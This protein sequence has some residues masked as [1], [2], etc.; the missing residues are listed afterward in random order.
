MKIKNSEL[1]NLCVSIARILKEEA[2][3]ST[4]MRWGLIRNKELLAGAFKS[5]NEIRTELVE[6]YAVK[7]KDGKPELKDDGLSWNLGD[8]EE[9][10]TED[11]LPTLNEEVEVA[12][13]MID[14]NDFPAQYNEEL[15]ANYDCLF[16]YI[17]KE[18]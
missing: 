2:G 15:K 1:Q 6:K 16:L 3:M 12:L 11:F 18:D 17:V 13:H 7:D 9:K 8:N 14:I 4:K 10:F 5:L